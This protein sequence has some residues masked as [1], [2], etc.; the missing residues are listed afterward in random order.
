VKGADLLARGDALRFVH[1]VNSR[2]RMQQFLAAPVEV[3][4]VDVAWGFLV[5]APDELRAVCA[6]PP[7]L[8]S[9]LAFEELFETALASGRIVKIDLKDLLAEDAVLAYLARTRPD[10]DRY[11]LNADMTIG[12]NGQ[13]P[14]FSA[15]DGLRWRATLGGDLLVSIGCTTDPPNG[16]YGAGDIDRLLAI[17]AEVGEP[18]TVCLDAHRLEVDPTALDAV[19]AAHR[20]VSLWNMQPA[21]PP[22]AR[23]YRARCPG[24]FID[25]FDADRAP[26]P[27]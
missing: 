13:E 17:A 18:C 24:A 11:F 2:A 21:D 12:P 16:P 19:L 23:R 6:H 22:M 7:V 5:G 3:F 20:H 8:Q 9:D 27:S 14:V 15:Q 26:V 25:L 4:E 1:G 10:V